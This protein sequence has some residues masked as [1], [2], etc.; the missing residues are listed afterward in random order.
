M[1]FCVNF[2]L[3]V[4]LLL[5]TGCGTNPEA[6]KIEIKELIP[7]A[8]GIRAADFDD[9]AR[10]GTAPKVDANEDQPLTLAIISQPVTLEKLSDDELREFEFHLTSTPDPRVVADWIMGSEL[11][12]DLRGK[13]LTAIPAKSIRNFRCQLKGDIA[14]GE[15]EYEIPD[16]C[17]G[18]VQFKAKKEQWK[19]KIVEFS[20][21][22]R[23]MTLTLEGGLWK[24]TQVKN[25]VDAEQ[26]KR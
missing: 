14:A 13:V 5:L 24:T 1:S 19:W 25:R 9:L 21:P 17:R 15:F 12:S 6:V 16:Y 3:L 20:M 18:C 11:R 10:G 8:A 22:A 23:G 4:A 26:S 2:S 7:S